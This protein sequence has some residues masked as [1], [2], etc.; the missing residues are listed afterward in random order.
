[1]PGREHVVRAEI[2][3]SER[4]AFVPTAAEPGL[5]GSWKISSSEVPAV[6][7]YV[8]FLTHPDEWADVREIDGVQRILVDGKSMNAKRVGDS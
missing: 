1:M 4:A 8:F 2:E 3:K 6:A 5:T 7:G